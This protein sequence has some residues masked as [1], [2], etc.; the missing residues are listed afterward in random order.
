MTRLTGRDV[1]TGAGIAVEVAAG[2][3]AAITPAEDADD[4][5]LAPGLVD[6][7]VNGYG[8]VDLNDGAVTPAS[9]KVLAQLLLAQGTTCFLPT[10]ITASEATIGAGLAALAT[11]IEG[12]ELVTAMVAGIHVEGP[13]I[14]PEDGPRG[15]H[16]REHVR[17][18][19][20]AEFERWQDAARG[21]IR[22][23]TL[24][25]HWLEAPDFIRH[26]S[27]QGVTVSI[28]HTD[29]TSA[30]VT[31]AVDAGAVLSTHL[32]NGAAAVLPR[33]PNFIWTQLAD[34]RLTACFIADGHHLPADTLKAMVRAKGIE[35][36]VLVSDVAALGGLPAGFYDQPIGG[37][38]EI[39]ADGRLGVAG[40]PY[41][42]GAG[43]LLA[44]D[45]AIA[46]NVEGIGLA[47]A[48][49][50]ATENA[51][52]FTGGRGRLAVGKRADLIR[53]HYRPGD[54]RLSIDEVWLQ[55][56]KRTP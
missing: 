30:E 27:R 9:V 36:S 31:A 32:G 52:R 14:S 24:S 38:V 45:V 21:H 17:K 1:Q 18:P 15:A 3:I 26:V 10:L 47:N 29:A 11:A 22:L 33:H 42:A 5:W 56:R 28:G 34:D 40:T 43:K 8:G 13:F 44:E 39:D 37:R 23:V 12:D 41:L 19:D 50:M 7:Q 25:P 16:P 4:C 53:F 2:H 6:L 51:G 54:K 55:G 20:I 49:R 35:R 46:A 48:M